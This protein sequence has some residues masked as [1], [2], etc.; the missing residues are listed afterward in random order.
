M[1]NLNVIFDFE[2]RKLT[3]QCTNEE[4]IMDICQRYATKIN[5]NLNSLLFLY[6]GN[7]L[8]FE[9]KLK[10][11]ISSIDKER[12]E[13]NVI[14][15]RNDVDEFIC[16]KCGEIIKLNTKKFDEIITH[17]N[18][19]LDSINRV[20]IQ[21]EG[22]LIN[23]SGNSIC[24][25]LENI[26]KKLI[27]VYGDMEINNEKLIK[28]KNGKNY[29]KKFRNIKE[30][31]IK[32]H[33]NNIKSNNIINKIFSHIDEKVKLKTIKYNKNLQNKLNI[34][35]SNYKLFSGN[36]IT[37]D[38]NGKGKE[39]NG[40]TDD[41]IFE[42]EYSNGE[43]NGKGKEYYENGNL[44]YEGEYLNDKRHGFGK[45]YNKEGI[46]IFEGEYCNGLRNG[47]GKEY[48][49]EGELKFE[50]SYLNGKKNGKCKEIEFGQSETEVEYLNGIRWTGKKYDSDENI[51]YELKDG[52]GYLK[53]YYKDGQ[54]KYEG[55]ILKG[56]KNGFG[57]EY[58]IDGNLKFE[59]KYKKIRI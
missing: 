46:L 9:P 36:Y 11:T 32:K 27:K 18:D 35:L 17:Y 19:I 44:K 52:N 28:V 7:Q 34:K 51:S 31:I 41:L 50:G 49:N 47:N 54:I 14:V 56:K 21:I 33:I 3:I 30:P 25:D 40:F 29:Y 6:G 55:N 22:I 59:G 8:N 13:M 48:K 42:G 57:K 38:I 23:N 20:K 16:L 58:Y 2:G 15:Y 45:E 10:D 1:I 53:E 39:Y 37:F 5:E 43:R 24:N 26:N 12:K 4:K